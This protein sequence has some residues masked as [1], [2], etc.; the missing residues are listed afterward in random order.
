M[1]A[2]LLKAANCEQLCN[3]K[4]FL[5]FNNFIHNSEQGEVFLTEPIVF[6]PQLLQGLKNTILDILTDDGVGGM[7]CCYQR[8]RQNADVKT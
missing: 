4:K 8:R 7:L 5:G 6:H 1:V 2:L 3:N